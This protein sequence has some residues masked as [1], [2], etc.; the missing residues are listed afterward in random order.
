MK[1]LL[2]LLILISA[3]GCGDSEESRTISEEQ[4][5]V[6]LTNWA[7]NFIIPAYEEYLAQ[8]DKMEEAFEAFN[9]VRSVGNLE[10]LRT[11]WIETYTAWQKVEIFQIGKAE[12]LNFQTYINLYPV[13]VEKI[14]AS[15]KGEEYNLELPS[16]RNQQGLSAMD[17][18][19]NGLADSDETIVAKYEAEEYRTYLSDVVSRIRNL[20]DQV[21]NDWK[22]AYREEYITNTSSSSGGSLDK[23]TNDFIFHFEK[24][25]RANKVS[26]AAGVFG[27]KDETS[28]EAFY[29]NDISRMLYLVSLESSKNFFFG[30][31]FNGD[32]QK[33]S[34]RSLLIELDRSDL[35][36]QIEKGY[37]ELNEKASMLSDSFSEQV[38]NDNTKMLEVHDASQTLVRYFK[39]DML[40]AL[41]IGIDYQDG[42]GD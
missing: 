40:S 12:S 35:V 39:T 26:N 32:D 4:S 20:S 27:S 2:Y 34:L 36:D 23:T 31:S 41:N 18:L 25:L 37:T 5:T 13:D 21:A 24:M 42:D 17:Y 6:I 7:D 28:V 11:R 9:S 22:G 38:L 16:R 30:N 15:I 14:E 29:K 19:L 8:L 33:E 1:K 10:T 3:F